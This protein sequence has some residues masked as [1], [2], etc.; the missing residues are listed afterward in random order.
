MRLY[1]TQTHTRSAG[2]NY[3]CARE[4]EISV[5]DDE[6]A[7][8]LVA[9][10]EFTLHR[11]YVYNV[12]NICKSEEKKKKHGDIEPY[13]IEYKRCVQFFLSL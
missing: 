4:C 1:C 10:T 5:M 11:L 2:Y 6:C 9:A 12:F 3:A 8:V 13:N 7:G